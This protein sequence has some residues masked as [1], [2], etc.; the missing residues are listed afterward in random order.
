MVLPLRARDRIR[1]P[2]E[3]SLPQF[4]A[5]EDLPAV[6]A[7]EAVLRERAGQRRRGRLVARD[8]IFE[9]LVEADDLDRQRARDP[10][11]GGEADV[12]RARQAERRIAEDGGEL[13][14]IRRLVIEADG[15]ADGDA[16]VRL[17]VDLQPRIDAE[18]EMRE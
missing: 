16:L 15:G 9:L 2:A 8:Q 4:L 11:G 18:F 7:A 13:V 3:E 6:A 14:G 17:V 12:Q 5:N 10:D 1:D